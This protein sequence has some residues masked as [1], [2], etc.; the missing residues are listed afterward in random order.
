MTTFDLRSDETTHRVHVKVDAAD[1]KTAMEEAARG[2]Q[3]VMAL[4]PHPKGSVPI[5]IILNKF[6]SQFR[7]GVT[8]KL[9]RKATGEAVYSLGLRSGADPQLDEQYRISPAKR[10]LGAFADDGGL[11]FSVSW[12]RPPA[13]EIRD[14]I[15]ISVE[16]AQG[17]REAAIEGQLQ[18][19]RLQTSSNKLVERPA[20]AEDVLVVDLEGTDGEGNLLH[21]A[22]FTDFV[23]RPKM[24][25]G[26]GFSDKLD[27]LAV[28]RSAGESF[29]FEE[30]YPDNHHDKYLRGQKVTFACTVREVRESVVPEINDEFAKTA[31]Y[32][33]LAELREAVGREWD[34]GNEVN[35]ATAKRKQVRKKIVEA[36]PLPVDE[37]VLADYCG[38][39]A[40]QF[41]VKF[42]DLL[43]APETAEIAE[44]IR[45]D[46]R[47]VIIYNEILDRVFDSHA[48]QLLL[49]EADI[50]KYAA[51]EAQHGVTAEEEI[52][53]KRSKPAAYSSWLQRS[54]RQ[55]VADW[56]VDQAVVTKVPGKE[57]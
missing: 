39:A 29:S 49:K 31:G 51:A 44:S 19:L 41:G 45:A 27:Q 3:A 40:E 8:E 7:S 46:Q 30:N 47:E 18:I 23:F 21:G 16:V 15:G 48:Q 24:R 34:A 14:Y 1:V 20:T 57:D 4:P 22:R 26:R 12:P 13:V 10:W 43:K 36:N 32:A 55:K 6:S 35:I 53:A 5:E 42:E 17:D 2:L 38:A 37:A 25:G 11:E 50:L 52:A 33:D 54:Q 28:G 56:I 9:V